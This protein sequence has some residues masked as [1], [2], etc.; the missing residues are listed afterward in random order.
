MTRPTFAAAAGIG[1]A[2]T[3]GFIGFGCSSSSSSSGTGGAT[4]TGGAV[5]GTGGKGTGGATGTGGG[6]DAGP[7]LPVCASPAPG[8]GTACNS[9]PS[10]T[11]NCGLNTSTLV[12]GRA[13]KACTCSGPSGTWSCPSTNGACVYPAALDLACFHIPSPV[14]ACPSQAGD[15]GAD[16]GSPLIKSGTT[17]CV[18]PNS[19]VCGNLCGSATTN[20]YL[21]GSNNPKM[22]YCVCI[23]GSY[24][25][26][27]VNEWPPQQ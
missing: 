24:Q 15:G 4:G 20:T 17:T 16:A 18:P 2:I 27:S 11:K 10:C 25:C 14:P 3:L 5:T 6:M 21:D 8:D 7:T 1:V 22:G 26:A 23:N 19:E 12:T 9:D 13:M